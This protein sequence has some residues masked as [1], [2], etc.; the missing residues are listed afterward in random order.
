MT[1]V[2]LSRIGVVKKVNENE[3]L[4]PRGPCRAYEELSITLTRR[5]TMDTIT[6]KGVDYVDMAML[7][8]SLNQYIHEHVCTLDPDVMVESYCDCERVQSLIS[9]IEKGGE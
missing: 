6:L 3:T 1:K 9:K 2:R 8:M 5:Y 7:V 4:A